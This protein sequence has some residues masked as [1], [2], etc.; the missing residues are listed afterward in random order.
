MGS[1]M[2]PSAAGMTD[3]RRTAPPN[4]N[5]APRLTPVGPGVAPGRVTVVCD[6]CQ[7][8]VREV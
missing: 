5:R 3:G 4:A 6:S 1:A 7:L 8:A 2:A